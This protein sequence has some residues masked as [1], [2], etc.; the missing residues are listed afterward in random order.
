MDLVGTPGT[1]LGA[2]ARSL[3]L[4]AA[5]KGYRLAA[6][7]T[8][9]LV[10]VAGADFPSLGIPEPTLEAVMPRDQLTYVVTDY[11]G[12]V[13]LT[14]A[15][16]YVFLRPLGPLA[17]ALDFLRRRGRASRPSPALLPAKLFWRR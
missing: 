16:T 17:L 13:Y 5:R 4:L 7:T 8:T 9:N 15:P 3:C 2:S 10:F 14:R 11:D 6:C 1:R 12:S